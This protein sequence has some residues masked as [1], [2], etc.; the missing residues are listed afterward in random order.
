M[1]FTPK[2]AIDNT[3]VAGQLGA[4]VWHQ[5]V[6][7]EFNR[8]RTFEPQSTVRLTADVAANTATALANV[9]GLSFPLESGD[10]Y[11][12]EFEVIYRSAATT[13]GI[14][15]GVT[16]PAFTVLAATVRIDGFAADGTG[17]TFHGPITTSGDSVMTTGTVVANTDYL[18]TV[19]GLIIPSAAGTLQLQAATEVAG[20]GVTIRNG[21]SGILVRNP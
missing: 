12:F 1:P 11:D 13:T 10:A 15:L 18:A 9:A 14:R 16:C 5:D 8:L 2:V 6:A 21:S 7:D 20:S 17:S 4:L 19:R 3:L